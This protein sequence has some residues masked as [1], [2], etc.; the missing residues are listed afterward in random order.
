MGAHPPLPAD[1]PGTVPRLMSCASACGAG[2][3]PA[4]VVPDRFRD[5]SPFLE[6]LGHPWFRLALPGSW[7]P[8]P[9]PPWP[10]SW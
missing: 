3:A 9:G 7:V 10:E 8:G 4:R 6:F 1:G 5:G 2:A